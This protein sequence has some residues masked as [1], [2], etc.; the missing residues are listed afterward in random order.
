MTNPNYYN[1]SLP[2]GIRL[3]YPIGFTPL[4]M[5][6]QAA[7]LLL[8]LELPFSIRALLCS[9]LLNGVN[10]RNMKLFLVSKKGEYPKLQGIV[11][12]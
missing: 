3:S 2:G 7:W 8:L 4:S 11:H 1:L 9:E 10:I 6:L 5:W 12:T